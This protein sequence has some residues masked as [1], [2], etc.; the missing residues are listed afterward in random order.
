M[1]QAERPDRED[2]EEDQDESDPDAKRADRAINSPEAEARA[3]GLNMPAESVSFGMRPER[4][5]TSPSGNPN[6]A[7]ARRDL[8]M[9]RPLLLI[10]VV[11]LLA[12]CGGGG[13]TEADNGGAIVQTIQISE[14]EF[15]LNPSTVNV[16]KTGTYEFEVTNDG[17]I[18]HSLNVEES[19]GGT[20]AESGDIEPGQTKRFRFTF[21]K[22]GSYEMYCPINGHRDQGM[23]G[24]ITV[25]S[26]AGGAGTTTTGE[27]ETEN[28]TTTGQTTTSSDPGY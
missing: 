15:S 6:V 1:D 24:T 27:T 14:K 18:T 2:S 28:E 12:G 23:E 3:R 25:G 19:G 21:S 16:S 8:E 13:S 9:I 11:V 5:A 26:A 7:P 4:L 17:Q 22:D 10:P 20:E